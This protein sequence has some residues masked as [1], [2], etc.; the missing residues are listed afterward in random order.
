MND[1]DNDHVELIGQ[2]GF[3]AEDLHGALHE[4]YAISK[5]TR[6]KQFLFSCSLNP[7]EGVVVTDAGFQDAANRVAEKLGLSDQPRSLVIHEKNG[8][9]HAHVVFSRIDADSM[10]AINL[11]HFKTK[12]R[13][14]SRELF[15]DHG[16]D[17]PEG[18][19]TYGKKNPLNFTLAEWQQA[20]RTGVDPREMKQLFQTAW[21]QSDDLQSYQSALEDKGFYLAQG[22]RRGFVALDIHG[23]TYAI[24]RWTGLRA[25]DV[26]ARLGDPR[27]LR[28]V[29]DV[30]KDLRSRIN[31]QVLSYIRQVKDQ[32]DRELQPFRDERAVMVLSQR[33]ER[34]HLKTKQDQRWD[35]ETE[36]RLSRLNTGIRSLFDRLTGSHQIKQRE[37]EAEAF[38]CAKRDQEQRERLVEAQMKERSDLQRRVR[39]LKL[40]QRDERQHMA[41]TVNAYLE[42]PLQPERREADFKARYPRGPTLER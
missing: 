34:A 21:A 1:L 7:P 24:G 33:E 12:L 29:G 28:L 16:W 9:R 13:D 2:T 41:T 39:A 8:R 40:R 27:E 26:K 14:V 19:Q 23:N 15:L 32:H 6:C 35:E 17:L 25:K 22:D 3:L 30:A 5:A 11:P 36:A 31:T 20:Q 42:R 37:N 4:A 18:L 10:T 38:T